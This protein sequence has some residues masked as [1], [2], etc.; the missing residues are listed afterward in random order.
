VPTP[1][2][3]ADRC[4]LCTADRVTS[5]HF[6]DQDCWIAD[7]MVCATPMVVWRVHGLPE[8]D[9]ES[10]L[11]ERL[12]EAASSRYGA[13]GFWIDGRRRRIPDHWHAHARPQG[14]FFDP[15]SRL[16]GVYEAAEGVRKTLSQGSGA[17]P[18]EPE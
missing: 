5:W 13:G 8:P 7:C 11:L 15:R 14:G 1:D 3:L 6:E 4:P 18:A 9:L 17:E 10:R 12:G 16:Y 2:P